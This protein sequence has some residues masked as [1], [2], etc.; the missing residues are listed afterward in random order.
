MAD[1]NIQGGGEGGSGT[2]AVLAVVIIALLAILAWFFFA[3]GG[4]DGDADIKVEVNA[5][6]ATGGGPPPPR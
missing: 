1:V 4:T 6:A 2:S 5:P 3:R